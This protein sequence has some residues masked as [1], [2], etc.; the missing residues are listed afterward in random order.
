M[1]EHAGQVIR[2]REDPR[3]VRGA[4]QFIDDFHPPDCLHVAIVRSPHAHARIRSIDA[5]AA[6]RAAGVVA[7]VTGADLGAA[8]APLPLFNEHPGLPRP[9]GIQPLA[10]ERVRFVGEPVAAVVA[11]DRYRAQDAAELIG[12]DYEPLPAVVDV[13]AAVGAGAPLVHEALGTNVAAEWRQRVGDAETAIREAPVVV[14]AT[15]RQAR[16]GAQPLETRGM[17]ARWDDGRLTVWAAIQM[18]HRHRRF[19]ARQLGLDEGQV[20]VIAPPDVG[21][22]FG[23]KG[24]FYPEDILVSALARLL[25]RPVKWIEDRREHLVSAWVERDQVHEIE[26]AATRDGR[27]LALRDRFLHELGAYTVSG[28][29]LPQNTMIHSLGPYRV[30]NV[31]LAFR[32]VLTNTTP[33]GSYRGAGR[34]Q[35]AFVAERAVDAVAR[36]LGLDPVEIRRR[37]LI[38]GSAHPYDTGLGTVGR[39]PVVYDSGDYPRCFELA[40]QALDYPAV[41]REQ[42][43]L[44]AE[45][46]WLGVGVVNY[47]EATGTVP[48]ESVAVRVATDGAIS[49]VTG[50]S[51][52]GQG[53]VTLLS[54]LVGDLLGVDPD[55]IEVLTGDTSLIATGGGTFGSRT[56]ALAGSAALLASRVVG[57]KARRI[58]AHL[59]EAAAEDV[60]DTRGRFAVR[61]FADRSV[62]WAD[63]A[64]AAH[65]GRVPGET[66]GLE[67]THVFT[68]SQSTFANGTHAA[69]IEVDPATGGLRILR[70]VVA[71]DCGRVLQP[72]LVD[73]QIHGGV[74][75]G[76]P[77]AL[78]DQLAYDAGGQRLTATL[79]DYA[80]ATAA[81]APPTFEIR[82]VESPTPLNPLGAKGAG[83]GG[84]MPVHPVIAQAVEDALAS[85]GARVTRVPVTRADIV[86][87]AQA[88]RVDELTVL[89]GGAV[90]TIV[91]ELAEA[92]RQETGRAV[93]VTF[94]TVGALRKQAV[95]E[96]ADVLILTD[97]AID[98]LIRQGI[99]A[100]GTRTDIARVG[101]GVA[102]KQGA[103]RPDVSSPEALRQTLLAAKSLVCADPAKGATSGVHFAEVLQRLG[104]AEHV[105]AKTLLWPEGFPARA[106]A[107]GQAELCVHQISGIVPVAGVSLVGPLP[108]ELQKITTYSAGLATR[109][110]QPDVARA[111]LAFLARPAFRAKFAA[112][113]MD[114][115][116]ELGWGVRS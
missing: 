114:Y 52:Q 10:T 20:R 22:G 115:R 42:A 24:Q 11:T 51:P 83:E 44:K 3:L 50:A 108:R 116:E 109:S 110:V 89:S 5:S 93:K 79:M 1:A 13:A 30:P 91:A 101:V 15:L 59:L 56:T 98:D 45:G 99:V 60:V 62:G 28:L 7:V 40:L 35:G 4:G 2:R 73:G 90:Q 47:I 46:R 78:N 94:A 6:A 96:P 34:P 21:G 80:L 54:H 58:A 14:R 72:G 41:R 113:G 85:F 18:V 77:D 19:I 69:V 31:E 57:D 104:I 38:E 92:Y 37:N 49:V 39:G 53:H 70:W 55:S 88:P 23:T 100:A 33:V 48:L 17:V 111:F 106:V 87:M 32:G 84:I 107:D 97:D 66:P 81:D 112:A 12:I 95:T 9:C 25:G 36:E 103:P 76:L 27:L 61:G 29:N 16:G 65:D 74:V 105:K 67:D 8:N 26:V 86:A 63:V 102:V 68:V 71:H 43:R 75:Q 64:A 82:H